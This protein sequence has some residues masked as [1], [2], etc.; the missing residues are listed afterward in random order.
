MARQQAL[1]FLDSTL[2]PK[3]TQDE[4]ILWARALAIAI[5]A[6]QSLLNGGAITTVE[7]RES[8]APRFRLMPGSAVS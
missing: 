6:R 5:G 1:A 8:E 3:Q 2:H 4:A 7:Q